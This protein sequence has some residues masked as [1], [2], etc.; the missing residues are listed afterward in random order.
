M[1]KY[2]VFVILKVEYRKVYDEYIK[3]LTPEQKNA[4]KTERKFLKDNQNLINEKKIQKEER[5][6]LGKPKRPSN[7]YML[8]VKEASKNTNFNTKT[9]KDDYAKISDAQKQKYIQTAQEL[10]DAYK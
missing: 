8:F 9:L 4:I 2:A 7:E 10:R 3:K 1:I 5:E 6:S